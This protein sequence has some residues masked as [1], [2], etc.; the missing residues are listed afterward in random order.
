W[1]VRMRCRGS[2]PAAPASQSVSNAY[3]NASRSKCHEERL[4]SLRGSRGG[5]LEFLERTS[6]PEAGRP[7]YPYLSFCELTSLVA[8]GEEGREVLGLVP[9]YEGFPRWTTMRSSA[10]KLSTV[11]GDC[12]SKDRVFRAITS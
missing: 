6:R 11:P 10:T 5:S 9:T 7:P 8:A 4:R 1:R 12:V 3:G 2:N